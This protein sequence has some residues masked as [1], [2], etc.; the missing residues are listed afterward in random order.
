MVGSEIPN[1]VEAFSIPGS[2]R[3]IKFQPFGRFLGEK[4]QILH[5]WKIQISWVFRK[6]WEMVRL[7]GCFELEMINPFGQQQPA[8][9]TQ[10]TPNNPQPNE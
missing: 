6:N 2:S 1:E 4:A 7:A 8:C 5:T 10:P 9:P 3:Y